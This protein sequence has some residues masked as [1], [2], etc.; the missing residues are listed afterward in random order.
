MNKK[1]RLRR[2][3]ENC[4]KLRV[5]VVHILVVVDEDEDDDDDDN[6]QSKDRE[7]REFQF[8]YVEKCPFTLNQ[9][10]IDPSTS[11]K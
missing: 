7:K 8:Y 2:N 3:C 5:S 10:L 4:T 6:H 1:K 11:S 9:Q